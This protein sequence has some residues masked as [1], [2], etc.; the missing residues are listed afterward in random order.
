MRKGEKRKRRGEKKRRKKKGKGKTEEK[1]ETKSEQ[2]NFICLSYGQWFLHQHLPPPAPTSPQPQQLSQTFKVLASKALTEVLPFQ[3]KA[4]GFD[5][6]TDRRVQPWTHL[7]MQCHIPEILILF[8]SLSGI[9]KRNLKTW[10]RWQYRTKAIHLD[11]SKGWFIPQQ[12][13]S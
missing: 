12:M 8:P 2:T 5:R 1:E 6:Q 4:T 11:Y 7:F 13:C 10:V 3:R 9:A